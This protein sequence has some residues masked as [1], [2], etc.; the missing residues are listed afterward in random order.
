MALEG[1]RDKAGRPLRKIGHCKGCGE[2]V[3][4]CAKYCSGCWAI[5]MAVCRERALAKAVAAAAVLVAEA[6]T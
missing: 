5:I 4:K 2:A 1:P 6:Q 3:S